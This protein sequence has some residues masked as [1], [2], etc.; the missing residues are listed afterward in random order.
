MASHKP[1]I[2]VVTGIPSEKNENVSHLKNYI[3]AIESVGGDPKILFPSPTIDS[4]FLNQID[5]LLLTG[6]GDIPSYLWGEVSRVIPTER[7]EKR[8][9]FEISL[10]QKA[11]EKKIPIFGICL[12]LQAINV[13]F[14]GTLYS[15]LSP[16]SK[17]IHCRKP[18]GSSSYHEVEVLASKKLSSLLPPT[19]QVNSRHHQAIQKLGKGLSISAKS[20]DHVIEAIEKDGPHWIVGVQWHPEDLFEKDPFQRKIFE[21]FILNCNR[22]L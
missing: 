3:S 7:D 1:K 5:G 12:G 16:E 11:H 10:I 2:A 4:N 6:G 9:L 8:A 15:D 14:G 18:D 17:Q 21:A 20:H 22:Q 13:A 19:T